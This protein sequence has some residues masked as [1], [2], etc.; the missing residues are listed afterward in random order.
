M[1]GLLGPTT[2]QAIERWASGFS[3]AAVALTILAGLAGY[4]ALLFTQRASE[5]KSK[6]LALVQERAA[7]AETRAANAQAELE[8]IRPRVLTQEQRDRLM[9]SLKPFS[10]GTGRF[11]LWCEPG[12][13][14]ANGLAEQF[15]A[16]FDEL[17]WGMVIAIAPAH[18]APKGV[19]IVAHDK[20]KLPDFAARFVRAARETGIPVLV[21]DDP[22]WGYAAIGV[23]ALIGAIGAAFWRSRP[24]TQLDASPLAGATDYEL[25]TGVDM[26]S[27]RPLVETNLRLQ[28]AIEKLDRTTAVLTIV[29][30]V[31]TAVGIVIALF[32]G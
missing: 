16:M 10:H 31:L 11:E 8:R 29:V 4:G 17:G 7:N 18:G 22:K 19:S 20:N 14:E 12:D 15:N 26:K 24:R 2:L 21:Q 28:R 30:I 13:Y 9:S 6:D 3:T 25:V 32:K 1:T 23:V 27:M 5:I